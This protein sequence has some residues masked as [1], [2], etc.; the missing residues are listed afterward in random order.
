MDI[1]QK[2]WLF[3]SKTIGVYNIWGLSI[4]PAY[5]Q[6]IAILVLFFFLI[7][8]LAR[9]RYLYIHWNLSKTSL[10]FL[11]YGFLLA[12]FLEG[13]LIIG[14]RTLFTATLGWKNAPKPIGTLIDIGRTQVAKVLEEQGSVP[15]SVAKV[16]LSEE[17]VI[18]SYFSLSGED[19]KKVRQRICT[20]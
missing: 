9:L 7:L 13:F 15:E 19:A 14:G 2:I 16:K 3:L 5:W 17:D 10:S 1:L 20:P 18:R 11:F 12:L 6:A 4:E 8:T